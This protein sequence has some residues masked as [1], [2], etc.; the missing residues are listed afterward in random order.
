[1]RR[2]GK[3]KPIFTPPRVAPSPPSRRAR[4]YG[5][6]VSPS[7]DMTSNLQNEP[8]AP[9][10][11]SRLRTA[12]L[13]GGRDPRGGVPYNRPDMVHERENRA[14]LVAPGRIEHHVA[15]LTATIAADVT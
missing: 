7:V 2:A 15:D 12:R 13:R 11:L 8:T 9:T 6:R 5:R 10:V 4:S 3:E 1:M 14:A